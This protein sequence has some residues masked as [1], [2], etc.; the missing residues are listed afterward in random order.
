MND[1]EMLDDYDFSE[2]TPNPYAK[3]L[4]RPITIRL[5]AETI[6]YF[7]SLATS[8]GIPYQSL[9]N[10]FLADCARNNK[11]PEISWK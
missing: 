10:M 6:Q 5:E 11:Q 4:K 9:M 7:K 8:T 2:S 3:R 1:S